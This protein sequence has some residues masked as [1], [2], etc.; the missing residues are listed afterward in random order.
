MALLSYPWPLKPFQTQHPVRG[1]LCDPRISDG[2]RTFHFGVDIAAP[3][4]TPVYA[5]AAGKVS[6]GAP[7]DIAQNGG[8]VVVQATGRNFGYWHVAPAIQ[9]GVNVKLN[10]LIGH[11]DN[12]PED[13]GHVHFAES[14]HAANG[15]TYWNPLRHGALTPF[16]DFG[17][18]VIE[19]VVTSGAPDALSG[20]VDLSLK[21]HDNTPI[22][23]TQPNPPGWNPTP[24]N[25][26][27]LPV[28]PA[29]IRWQLVQD[30]QI[31]IPWQTAVDFTT[32][33]HPEVEG[34]PASDVN[35]GA[36]YAP[37][38]TQNNPDQPGNYH[39]WLQRGLD[40][41]LHPNGS[42]VIEVEA[43]DVRQNTRTGQLQVTIAN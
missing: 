28:T 37:D 5:V 20:N 41:T 40:T 43:S 19:A 2:G 17:P 29:L 9:P 15:I 23:V 35:F 12:Q 1:F 16:F 31:V 38:T 42:Y 4:G 34:S 11:I 13:W 32:S 27:G 7:G 8:I 18:P 36:V 26:Y 33:F 39:F 10:Q 21:A 14:T 24:A 22:A 6:Y 3:A 25:P 30:G